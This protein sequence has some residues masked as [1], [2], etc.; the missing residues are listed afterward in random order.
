MKK[1]SKYVFLLITVFVL[2]ACSANNDGTNNEEQEP[3]PPVENDENGNAPNEEK[4]ND[5]VDLEN[6]DLSNFFL[7]DETIA[8]YEGV[9]NEFSEL[10]IEVHHIGEHFVVVDEDNGGVTI[11][12]IYQVDNDEIVVLSETP[13]DLIEELP[14][15]EGLSKLETQEVY[16]K[17]PLEIGAEFEDWTIVEV[18]GTVETPYRNFE[19]VIVIESVDK[20]F[21]NRRYLV[22]EYGEVV[23]ESIMETE[24]AEDFIVISS[25]KLIE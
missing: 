21:T 11:R 17:K 22:P 7:P 8:H 19:N 15:E 6:I 4:P 18:E 23:R 1:I 2:V 24:D 16:L 5:Q 3:T 12:K 20:D 25:L 14:N 10:N 9:G 13:I